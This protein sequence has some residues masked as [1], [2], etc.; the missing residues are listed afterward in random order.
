MEK[1]DRT[2]LERKVLTKNLNLKNREW[3]YMKMI[4]MILPYGMSG[5]KEDTRKAFNLNLKERET[6]RMTKNEMVQ[7]GIGGTQEVL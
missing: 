2:E 6:S 4:A 3:S 5:W 1:Q 7:P